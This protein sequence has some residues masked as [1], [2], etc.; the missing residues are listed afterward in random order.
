MGTSAIP[1][2]LSKKLS[3]DKI[4]IN[5]MAFFFMSYGKSERT[6]ISSNRNSNYIGGAPVGTLKIWQISSGE[7]PFLLKMSFIDGSFDK[8]E[9]E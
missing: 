5:K 3:D 6:D 1:Q 4:S 8:F 2:I 9:Q 7:K